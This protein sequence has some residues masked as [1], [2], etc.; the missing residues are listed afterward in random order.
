ME[1]SDVQDIRRELAFPNQ[2]K[3]IRQGKRTSCQRQHPS[4]F[5]TSAKSPP[6]PPA[7]A[8]V[9]MV[10]D[11]RHGRARLSLGARRAVAAERHAAGEACNR[12]PG[13]WQ[14]RPP[15]RGPSIAPV[16]QPRTTGRPEPIVLAACKRA[17]SQ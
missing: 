8:A 12:R 1:V 7:D 3:R 17:I 4:R 10:D 5:Q 2:R 11:G 13:M 14:G 16:S 6:A 9:P 15:E